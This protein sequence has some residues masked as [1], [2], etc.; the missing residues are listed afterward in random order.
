MLYAEFF[1]THETV[2]KL[3][4]VGFSEMQAETQTK[5]LADLLE[6]QNKYLD[7]RLKGLESGLKLE[8]SKSKA[9]IYKWL[10]G[11]LLA[12]LALICFLVKLL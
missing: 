4:A 10:S 11:M 3:K 5:I 2:K 1:D 12:Q 6:K 8:I 9:E 7:L